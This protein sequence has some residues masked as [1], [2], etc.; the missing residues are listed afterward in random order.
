MQLQKIQFY[1]SYISLYPQQSMCNI[2]FFFLQ[3]NVVWAPFISN[4][5]TDLL[6]MSEY[7]ANAP[8]VVHIQAISRIILKQSAFRQTN[9]DISL[10]LELSQ[11]QPDTYDSFP[12]LRGAHGNKTQGSGF[13][14]SHMPEGA[15]KTSS[16]TMTRKQLQFFFKVF[17]FNYLT[18]VKN[19]TTTFNQCVSMLC[20]A[21]V[22]CY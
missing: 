4:A 11:S 10:P 8:N 13:Q 2:S 9:R 12:P 18:L 20:H 22:F 1:I 6:S 3:T 7:A 5:G 19:D 15:K 16:G 21:I 17:Q 14:P